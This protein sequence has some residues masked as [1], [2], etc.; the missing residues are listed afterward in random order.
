MIFDE[1][2]AYDAYTGTLLTHLVRWL[3][4]LGSSVI[5][6]SATLPPSFRDRLAQIV[7]ADMPNKEPEYPRLSVFQTGGLLQ[8]HFDIDPS[9]RRTVSL[10]KITTDLSSFHASIMDSLPS[11]GM[12]L[13][14]VNT[15]Q[16]AQD[17]F[18]LFP[19]ES[20][21]FVAVNAL[22][23]DYPMALKCSFSTLA[24]RPTSGKAGRM[25][26]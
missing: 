19:P 8:Y 6:L 4:A 21:S 12:G 25:Q 13:A 18:R 16:R 22:E 11:G 3:L 10:G 23:S 5:L 20:Q 14:I 15:V 2:H 24:T 7:G 1:I 9:F 26:Q 17:L